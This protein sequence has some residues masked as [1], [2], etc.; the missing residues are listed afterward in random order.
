MDKTV[1]YRLRKFQATRFKALQH[2]I[3]WVLLR[4][5]LKGLA[6]VYGSDNWGHQRYAEAYMRHFDDLRN[7]RVNIL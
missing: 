3:F 5:N 2:V 7:K 1:V 4:K 6:R